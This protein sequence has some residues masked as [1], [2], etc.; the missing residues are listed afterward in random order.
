MQINSSKE[1]PKIHSVSGVSGLEYHKKV[2]P[3]H[4]HYG[5]GRSLSRAAFPVRTLAQ[6]MVQ[7]DLEIMRSSSILNNA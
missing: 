7:A 1:H 4:R 5:S 3:N 6:E 2:R